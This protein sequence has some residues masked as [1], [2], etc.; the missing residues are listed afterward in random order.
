MKIVFWLI[1]SL[2]SVINV[3]VADDSN[4]DFDGVNEE[5]TF[6]QAGMTDWLTGSKKKFKGYPKV[7]VRTESA[8]V[9]SE[10]IY[11]AAK[12]APSEYDEET[13]KLYGV[14]TQ[15]SSTK[16]EVAV[17]VVGDVTLPGYNSCA[18]VASA[19]LKKAGVRIGAY[20]LVNNVRR[21]LSSN[22]WRR[23]L[24]PSK[25]DIVIWAKRK[26]GRTEWKKRAVVH[27]K[28]NK[29]YK[30]EIDTIDYS[31]NRYYNHIGVFIGWSIAI[32][33]PVITGGSPVGW[34]TVDNSSVTGE[35]EFRP[36]NRALSGW[37]VRE[38]W[39]KVQ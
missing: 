31:A 18:L 32:Q 33:G 19:I 16:L 37:R 34:Y 7:L 10:E 13:R 2:F 39:T 21:Y 35:P 12:E 26:E 1:V 6:V 8:K 5:E 30:E 14:R 25:G 11:E 38:I 3:I 17:P 22:G 24:T 20:A 23:T 27:W 28:D 36:Y 15:N 9:L 29:L 4:L